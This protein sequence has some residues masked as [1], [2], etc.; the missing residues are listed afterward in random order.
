MA[1][2]KRA[3]TPSSAQSLPAGRQG[4]GEAKKVKTNE[5]GL[6][7]F[8]VKKAIGFTKNFS[9]EELEELS[10]KLVTIYHDA[11][12]GGDELPVALEKFVLSL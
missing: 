12:R 10:R 2:I 9:Q 5:L 7:P 8:V 11:R 3:E 1:F 4:S 6:H